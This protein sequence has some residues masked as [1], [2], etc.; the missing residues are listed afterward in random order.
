MERGGALLAAGAGGRGRRW[1]PADLPRARAR[2][3]RA[4]A[5]ARRDAAVC[6]VAPAAARR[7]CACARRARPGAG[8]AAADRGLSGGAAECGVAAMGA[9]SCLARRA[10]WCPRVQGQAHCLRSPYC[11]QLHMGGEA[12]RMRRVTASGGATA[13]HQLFLGAHALH[14]PAYRRC[15]LFTSC[16]SGVRS[17]ADGALPP[18]GGCPGGATQHA[19]CGWSLR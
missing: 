11:E 5:A 3:A 10:C 12:L 19:G 4:A 9:V 17:S 7:A 6:R 14:V 18:S 8:C 1:R 2:R 16:M 15:P 13:A